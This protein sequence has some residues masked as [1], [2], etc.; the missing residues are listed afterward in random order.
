L[1][2]ITTLFIGLGCLLVAQVSGQPA[3][4]GL[5]STSAAA[6]AQVG[7]KSTSAGAAAQVRSKPTSAAAPAQGASKPASAARSVPESSGAESRPFPWNIILNSPRD[8]DE[9][10]QK[11]ERPDLLVTRPDQ[12]GAAG[13]RQA[14]RADRG[15]SGPL[16]WA[17]QSVLVEGR[18]AVDYADLKASMTIVLKGSEAVWVPIQLDDQ[19]V[20]SAREG[21]RELL[22]QVG[23]RRDW[24]VQLSGS[25]VHRI[26]VE[27]RAPVRTDPARKWLSVPIPEAASTRVELDC[28]NRESDLVLGS[29][30]EYGLRDL[31]EGKPRRLSAHLSPRS[32]L[33]VT[34]TIGDGSGEGSSPLLTAQGE[35]AIDVEADLVRTRASWVIRCIRGIARNLEFR[36]DAEEELTELLVD[37]L[38]TEGGFERRQGKLAVRLADM[39]RPGQAKRVVMKT[40]RSFKNPAIRRASFS[41]FPLNGAKEQTG[42]IGVIQ[43][44]NLWVNPVLGRGT[45]Q[46]D[47]RELPTDLRARPSTNLA[48]EFREQ[49]FQVD[50]L[51][52]P[53]PPL[54][55]AGS[56]TSFWIDSERARSE[57][58][59]DFSW[60]RGRV[61]DVEL[62]VPVGLQIVSIGPPDVVETSNL[63]SE[64]SGSAGAG[65]T[66]RRLTIRLKPA[67][68]DQ[69]KITVDVQGLQP[70]PPGGLAKVG[71]ITPL[72]ATSVAAS[73][74]LL[75]ERGLVLELDEESGRFR[76]SYEPAAQVARSV[77]R[78]WPSRARSADG[79]ATPLLLSGD[80]SASEL[81]IRIIR[82][83]RTVTHDTEISAQVSRRSIDV[84]QQTNLVVHFGVLGSLEI[85]VPAAIAERWELIDKEIAERR[86][87]G[88]DPDGSRRYRLTFERP[89][90]D[91][92]ALRLRYRLPLVPGLDSKT[93]REIVLPQI[94]VKEGSPGPTK[95]GLALATDIALEASNPSWVRA[96]DLMPA[97]SDKGPAVAFVQEAADRPLPPFSFIAVPSENVP[98]PAV[99][100]PRLLVRTTLAE[101][102]SRDRAG[103]WVES[104]GTDFAI[105][106]PEGAR[107]L[108]ARVDGRIVEQV[109]YD[110]ATRQYRLRFP[111]E[112]GSRPAL[113]EIEYQ[114]S[115]LGSGS[116]RLQAP[117]LLDGGVVLQSIWEV[118]VP[119]NVAILGV[120]PGWF[121]EN[122]WHWDGY[123]SK[124]GP[125]Q[126]SATLR[127]WLLGAPLTPSLSAVDLV[128]DS[129]FDESHRSVFV[130]SRSGGPVALAIWL[131]PW[132]WLVGV[133]SGATLVLGFL[134]IFSG[135]RF[136][137]IWLSLAVVGLVAGMF[138]Q[139]SALFLILQSAAIGL[140]LTLLGL[141]I[142]I[143]IERSRS[144][145][146]PSRDSSLLT[147]RPP[148]D[149]SLDESSRVGSDDSTAVRVRV[150]STMELVPA[151]VV[152]PP[153]SD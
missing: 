85:R 123:V 57:T 52:E 31:G 64:D 91:K 103:Y 9:L 77:S 10:W 42:F 125:A 36:I 147:V 88:V 59:I 105:S 17:V 100:V 99:L 15:D 49:P 149:S 108:S 68:R 115:A 109:D 111:S 46:I 29:N 120:P 122:Q 37:D 38:S 24:Q 144:V 81:P 148:G 76:R 104:H 65:Q 54:V 112:T 96:D 136:R 127:G 152:E 44:P 55:K 4:V 84:V 25:G 137:E 2:R 142:R 47:P 18:V 1:E 13:R 62:S 48:L 128:D 63:T 67:A 107:W 93:R 121:D 151:P 43:S 58:T 66:A 101:D 92:L 8:L 40:R 50:L 106:I 80:G 26:Q 83:E 56:K 89:I 74:D 140:A 78:D 153:V 34:W 61:F 21:D 98:M 28:F 35:I 60:V 102:G 139:P 27:F 5:K 133:C 32:K 117:R 45:R 150:P 119:G 113:V 3:Q 53:L 94:T 72:H 20:A 135:A 126:S 14:E 39:L 97:A 16:L 130:F 69:N 131:V 6:P 116:R 19:R 12:I 11:I 134:A 79:D 146:L 22:L 124:Q 41:G 75:A 7:S 141:V 71:L 118:R 95:V 23:E 70:I 30:E 132:S 51:V 143:L 90:L 110:R 33:E 87:L 129:R 82:H 86:E 145:R 138:V 114:T 73:Y